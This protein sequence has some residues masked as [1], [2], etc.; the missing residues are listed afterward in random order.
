[1]K[2]IILRVDDFFKD[3]ILS[4]F[5]MASKFKSNRVVVDNFSRG[6]ILLTAFLKRAPELGCLLKVQHCAT[7]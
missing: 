2:K 7:T 6:K 1:M 4:L 3:E 5:S